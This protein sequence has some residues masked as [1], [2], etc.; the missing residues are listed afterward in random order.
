MPDLYRDIYFK[1]L[2]KG[3]NM[4]NLEIPNEIQVPN[5]FYQRVLDHFLERSYLNR[6]SKWK[7]LSLASK[8]GFISWQQ[9]T[10]LP[11]HPDFSENYDLLSRW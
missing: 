10:R 9:M 6:S 1:D 11:I 4:K 7:F 8:H 3:I 2:F 5:E